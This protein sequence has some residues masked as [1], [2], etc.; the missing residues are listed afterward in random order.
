M[1]A[2]FDSA[3]KAYHS[4]GWPVLPLPPGQKTPPPA[5]TTGTGGTRLTTHQ[6][7]QHC[8][9]GL[10]I[11]VRMPKHILGIDVDQYG[12]KH[13]WDNL[14]AWR[15]A[16]G[17]PPLPPTW[18][19]TSRGANDPSGIQWFRVPAGFVTRGEIVPGVEAIQNHHRYAVAPPSVH[20]EGREYQWVDDAGAIVAGMVPPFALLAELPREWVQTLDPR[21]AEQR[22]ETANRSDQPRSR[23][24]PHQLA[25]SYREWVDGLGDEEPCGLVA[26][27]VAKAIRGLAS[28]DGRSRHDHTL[29]AT[30]ALTRC[31]G[32]GHRGVK[33]GLA[34]LREA[35]VL[36]VTGDDSREPLEA[37]AE[38]LRLFANDDYRPAGAPAAP[39]PCDDGL[40]GL[41]RTT[42]RPARGIQPVGEPY[43]LE[44]A[45]TVFQRWLGEDYDTDALDAVLAT[46]AVERLTGDPLWMLLI[47]GSGNAK[48]ETVQALS[49]IGAHVVSTITSEGAL[50]SATSKRERATDATGGLLREIGDRGVAVIKDVTSI[51]S[52]NRDLRGQ[53]LGALRE[54]YDGSWVR[55]VGTDGGRSLPWEGRIAVVGAV[56]TAW[57]TAHSVIASMGDRFVLV[58]MNSAEGRQAAG[59]HAIGN[60]GHEI[61][62]RQELSDATARVLANLDETLVDE[63][64][65][66]EVDRLLA[67]ADVV[68]LARTGVEYD[69]QGNVID[70]HAPE[71]PTRFAK[72]LAQIV[73]GLLALGA[74]RDRAMRL[75]IRCARDSM[76]PLRLGIID[77]LATHPDS[78]V[79]EIRQRL[80]KPRNTVDRQLQALHMLGVL[81]VEEEDDFYRGREVTVWRYSLASHIDPEALKPPF[82]VPE[83]SVPTPNPLEEGRESTG[84]LGTP[85]D[86]SGTLS[87]PDHLLP[88][89]LNGGGA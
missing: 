84:S 70:A 27:V 38:W 17:L 74:D 13:G 88:P 3:W 26:G 72:Q 69:Y 8:G 37:E 12:N 56:T 60:T 46:A 43:T 47:S 53:V 85:T 15:Q 21:T 80:G 52:M 25:D 65:P 67:A 45:H 36:A 62:M 11:G 49:G 41:A 75:A 34:E 86:K 22:T 64:T 63:L 77:D 19:S 89:E 28:D 31:V 57:D 23:A 1:T 40:A 39:D 79:K 32:E 30:A 35:F 81:E 16:Q 33:R 18:R 4:A 14:E 61:Q 20:P 73:R 44:E 6:L 58:R 29:A 59:R 55:K 87:D 7:E 71:M 9:R 42:P 50:L 68:T 51:L 76:P 78:G 66:E 24:L 83:K 10:N 5:G 82:N 54:I 48:T 2:P